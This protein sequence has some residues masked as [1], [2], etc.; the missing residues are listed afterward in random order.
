MI[1]V[2]DGADWT[3]DIIA[4]AVEGGDQTVA[5][6]ATKG[7]DIYAIRANATPRKLIGDALTGLTLDITSTSTG[8][9][10]VTSDPVAITGASAGDATINVILKKGTDAIADTEFG[11]TVT[12]A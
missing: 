2:L 7:V 4:L 8:V 6:G 5:S 3:K 10:T 11:V 1:Q 9:V 12:S